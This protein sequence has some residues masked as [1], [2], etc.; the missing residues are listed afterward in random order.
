MA[1]ATDGEEDGDAAA[2]RAAGDARDAE[3][4]ARPELD[5]I[6]PA[7]PGTGGAA[8]AS[9]DCVVCMDTVSLPARRREYMVT[10]CDHLFHTTCLRPWIEQKLECPTCRLRLPEP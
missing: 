3:L 4:R 7:P 9:V 5:D 8:S 10:P 1:A 2:R 6:V